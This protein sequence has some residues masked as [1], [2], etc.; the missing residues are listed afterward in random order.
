[1]PDGTTQ[2]SRNPY[3]PQWGYLKVKDSDQIKEEGEKGNKT[4]DEI[5]NEYVMFLH[6]PGEKDKIEPKKYVRFNMV[7]A[8]IKVI[9]KGKLIKREVWV[10]LIDSHEDQE[11][12]VK[13]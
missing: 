8:E 3:S 2:D 5:W 12:W 9:N 4:K 7:R 13:S 11:D 6:P 1:M 10:A